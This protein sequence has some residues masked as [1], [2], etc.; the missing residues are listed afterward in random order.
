MGLQ[1]RCPGAGLTGLWNNPL[2]G[3]LLLHPLDAGV[4]GDPEAMGESARLELV[5]AFARHARFLNGPNG[6][7][8][9]RGLNKALP[10]G[11]WPVCP[12][13][14]HG[15]RNGH[16]AMATDVGLPGA[17][18]LGALGAFSRIHCRKRG[19]PGAMSLEASQQNCVAPLCGASLCGVVSSLC[20]VS[21]GRC[22]FV[23]RGHAARLPACLPACLSACLSV[24][25]ACVLA[26]MPACLRA[27]LLACLCGV[28]LCVVCSALCVVCRA[29]LLY[30]FCFLIARCVSIALAKSAAGVRDVH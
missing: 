24:W 20:G 14:A 23:R 27:C 6:E 17:E 30:V 19:R 16:H 2:L 21:G 5:G 3:H 28:V 4:G 25:Y 1:Q 10:G 11:L 18:E 12:N 7:L 13:R 9:Q 22:V 8:L 26:C 15:V 29:V